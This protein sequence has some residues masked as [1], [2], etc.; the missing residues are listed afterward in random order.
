VAKK[1]LTSAQIHNRY[2][3]VASARR[4]GNDA[5]EE[6]LEWTEGCRCPSA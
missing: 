5:K 1:D 4:Q 3:K 6:N 2:Q